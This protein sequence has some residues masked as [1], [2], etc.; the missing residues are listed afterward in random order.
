MRFLTGLT[1]LMILMGA[2]WSVADETAVID[3]ASVTGV[4]ITAEIDPVD[5]AWVRCTIDWIHPTDVARVRVRGPAEVVSTTLPGSAADSTEGWASEPFEVIAGERSELLLILETSDKGRPA[6][7]VAEREDGSVI[8]Q[9]GVSL[10]FDGATT[11]A[12]PQVNFRVR[13][14]V[15][16]SG[17]GAVLVEHLGPKT[18]TKAQVF[19]EDGTNRAIPDGPTDCSS[20]STIWPLTTILS[21]SSAP[22]GAVATAVTVHLTVNHPVMANLQ[23]VFSKEFFT[24]ARYLWKNGAGVSLNQDFTTD[25]FS[26]TL[27]GVGE[28]VNGTWVLALRDCD[29]G[30]TG[31]LDYWSVRIDYTVVATIDLVRDG[32]S[33]DPTTVEP[34]GTVE[35]DWDGD[36][37]GTGTVGGPFTIGFYLSTDTTITTGDVLLGSVVENTANNPGDTFGEASPGRMLTIPGG[38]SDGT[39]Y[40]GMIIDSADAI[41]E[42][43]ETNNIAWSQIEVDTTPTTIDLIADSVTTGVSSVAAGDNIQ[44]A[45]A[46]H[47]TGNGTIS[48]PFSLGFYLSTDAQ[49]TPIDLLLAQRVGAWATTGGDSFGEAAYTVN[50]PPGTAATAAGTYYL[51]FWIDNTAAVSESNESNNMAMHHPLTVT[52]GGGGGGGGGQPNLT[53][54]P[55]SVVPINVRP[56]DKVNLTWRA[57]NTG[58]VSSGSFSSGIYLSSDADID[59]GTDILMKHIDMASW[60]A[61]IDSGTRSPAIMLS[62]GLSDG[63]YYIGV[64]LDDQGGVTESDET[65]NGCATQLQVGPSAVPMTVTKWLVPAAASAPGFGTSNWKSQIAV[66]N[67]LNTTRTASL[68]YVVNGAP[69]PG[70]LL[71]G[72]MTIAATDRAYFDDVLATLNP[73]AGL[74]YVVLDEAGP[75]V[76]SRTYNLE[77]GG[78][79]FGQGI[80]AIPFEGVTPPDVVVL[81]MIHTEPGKFHTN[82]GLVHA[83]TGNLLVRVEVFNAAGT[84][85]GTKNYSHSAAW[86]QV[87]DVFGDMGLGSQVLYG[88]WFRVTRIAGTG[89]WTCYASVVDDLTNDPT[90]VAPVEVVEP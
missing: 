63:L 69:W 27:P 83:A 53:A 59:P 47:A 21:L 89:F 17:R 57:F 45:Y 30:S 76:N 68:Y 81:P 33:V 7:I 8:F 88:G 19:I 13:N 79:S 14:E 23:I 71:S 61:G 72:P 22:S 28:P 55:C 58:V 56:G 51:G 29:A 10:E 66:V 64:I 38:T 42:T 52:T 43:N 40:L 31:I 85:I 90:Y 82:L 48:V 87:N 49:V 46:G 50:I 54:M 3:P 16:D 35:V 75:V 6:L 80:P 20:G 74:L 39:Y 70:A 26:Q 84:L 65:D 41:A 18:A 1:C 24:V 5:P 37:A 67:P 15:L 62:S 32:L 77:P 36:V 34:G 11:E 12:S 86:R 4:R 2:A 44:V 60:P 78:A 9:A 25:V 73:T